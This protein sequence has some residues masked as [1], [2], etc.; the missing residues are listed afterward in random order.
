MFSEYAQHSM[1][2]QLTPMQRRSIKNSNGAG[3]NP[4]RPPTKNEKAEPKSD[5]AESHIMKQID[6]PSFS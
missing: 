5:S 4:A 1:T 2:G 3:T 6:H